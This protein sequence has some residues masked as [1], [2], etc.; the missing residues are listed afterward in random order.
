MLGDTQGRQGVRLPRA[1]VC[2][3]YSP[4]PG[5]REE[6]G[7]HAEHGERGECEEHEECEAHGHAEP[8]PLCSKLKVRKMSPTG[9]PE[10][11]WECTLPLPRE[12]PC[13]GGVA[14]LPRGS[15]FLL[16]RIRLSLPAGQEGHTC[17]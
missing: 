8:P 6:V 4:Q 1:H 10:D 13:S 5:E 16:L 17:Y 14:R 9:A 12:L 11:G 15:S 2:H 7:E 3:L